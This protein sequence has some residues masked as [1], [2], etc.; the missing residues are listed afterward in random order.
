MFVDEQHMGADGQPLV[1]DYNPYG[2]YPVA[3]GGAVAAAVAAYGRNGGVGAPRFANYEHIAEGVDY[4]THSPA[5]EVR[6]APSSLMELG[7]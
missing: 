5:S 2:E 1:V 7:F 4:R 3:G 6:I